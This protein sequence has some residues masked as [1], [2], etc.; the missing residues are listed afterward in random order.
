MSPNDLETFAKVTTFF[1]QAIPEIEARQKQNA[2][3]AELAKSIA[4]KEADK[5]GEL[6]NTIVQLWGEEGSVL[7]FPALRKYFFFCVLEQEEKPENAVIQANQRGEHLLFLLDISSSMNH[8]EQGNYQAPGSRDHQASS[9][10]KAR[11]LIAPLIMSALKRNCPVTVVPWNSR[12]KPANI[13]EFN[14]KDFL[15]GETGELLDDAMLQPEL[16]KRTSESVFTASSATNIE[17]ALK[18]LQTRCL[19][20]ART[21]S[22]ISMWFLTDGEET[23]YLGPNG[24]SLTIPVNPAD[25]QYNYFHAVVDGSTEYQKVMIKLMESLMKRLSEYKTSL[26]CHWCHF[27]EADPLF[28]R[29]LRQVTQGHFHAVA[30][31]SK[32]R[33]EMLA[34][35]HAPVSKLAM[36]LPSGHEFPVAAAEAFGTLFGRGELS[37]EH[38]SSIVEKKSLKLKNQANQTLALP[39]ND[40]STM[41]PT[42]LT[43]VET[44]LGL[45]PTLSKLMSELNSNIN[46]DAINRVSKELT[47]LKAARHDAIAQI[48]KTVKQGSLIQSFLEKVIQAVEGQIAALSRML[49]QYAAPEAQNYDDKQA[50]NSEFFTQREQ[51]AISAGLESMKVRIGAGFI[52]QACLDKRI[53]QI[54]VSKGPWARKMLRRKCIIVETER[55]EVTILSLLIVDDQYRTEC[56]HKLIKEMTANKPAVE[57]LA[58]SAFTFTETMHHDETDQIIST[59]LV[60]SPGLIEKRIVPTRQLYENIC[61][62]YTVSVSSDDLFEAKK[63]LLDPLSYANFLELIQENS[64]LPAY[65]YTVATDQSPGLLFSAKEMLAVLSGGSDITSFAYFRLFWRLADKDKNNAVKV[66]GTFHAANAALPM[67]PDP[68]SNLVLAN[69]MPGLMSEFITGTPMAPLSEIGIIY[70][71]Y[72]LLHLRAH[73]MVDIDFQRVGEFLCTISCWIDNPKTAPKQS[74][75]QETIDRIV[76]DQ[77]ITTQDSPGKVLPVKAIA[78]LLIDGN[79]DIEV[80]FS[81]LH[82]EIFNRLT[83]LLTGKISGMQAGKHS[84]RLIDNQLYLRDYVNDVLGAIGEELAI[85]PKYTEDT[86]DPEIP[87]RIINAANAIKMVLESEDQKVHDDFFSPKVVTI[88]AQKMHYL[89]HTVTE[90]CFGGNTH[91]KSLQKL[92]FYF[93]IIGCFPLASLKKTYALYQEANAFLKHCKFHSEHHSK[94]DFKDVICSWVNRVD[95]R[96]CY[97]S[98]SLHPES[99]FVLNNHTLGQ[100][101]A[102]SHQRAIIVLWPLFKSIFLRFSQWKSREY[103][104]HGLLE[105][106][107]AVVKALKKPE[108]QSFLAGQQLTDYNQALAH[109]NK[110]YSP[111]V[112][113]APEIK[114]LQNNTKV[115]MKARELS[116]KSRISVVF[117]GA[118]DAGKSTTAGQ[119]ISQSGFIDPHL[120]KQ[121]EK[122]ARDLGKESF[123]FAW[124]MDR[125]KNERERGI[126][127]E[128]SFWSIATP[129]HEV[130][131]LDAP[132]HR[133][134]FKNMAVGASLADCAILVASAAPQEFEPSIETEGML[135]QEAFCAFAVGIR[136]FIVCVNKMDAVNYSEARFNEVSF[137][138]QRMLKK[139]GVQPHQIAVV[140]ISAWKGLNLMKPAEEFKWFQGWSWIH[141]NKTEHKGITLQ[142]AMDSIEAPER[143]P[144]TPLRIP[145]LKNHKI[146]GIG[147][148]G[149]GRVA[150][151]VIKK[152][153]KLVILP[154]A[155]EAE[156]NTIELHHIPREEGGPGDV[157]G[158]NVKKIHQ[159]QL[160]RGMVAVDPKVPLIPVKKFVIRVAITNFKNPIKVGWQCFCFCHTASF[161]IKFTKLVSKMDKKTGKVLEANPESCTGGDAM[162]IEVETEHKVCVEPFATCPPLGRICCTQNGK[163]VALGVVMSIVQEAPG[164]KTLPKTGQ[165]PPGKGPAGRGQPA[166][167]VP[168]RGRR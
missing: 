5:R 153:Q 93:S 129:N 74:D 140:P 63:R 27:G 35:A 108:L 168:A 105:I 161:S 113:K 116:D 24:E 3:D 139:L 131:I 68:L 17:A 50:A 89:L 88:L 1:Y 157:I 148:V 47:K 160:T 127:I 162:M 83:K 155:I 121:F 28:L 48:G 109:K 137:E 99:S 13:V 4:K 119:M 164:P 10:K 31:I 154:D 142:D 138:M 91:W 117:L 112:P 114:Q 150:S 126:S 19:E 143:N 85:H 79:H 36:V 90:K 46:L 156:C 73:T 152:G 8:D 111:W 2:A 64:T 86:A 128:V 40:T 37:L 51:F 11:A 132:G 118:V 147:L 70:T 30:D 71:G 100:Q 60:Q 165:A 78:Y 21:C 62:D 29:A 53:Q 39:Y 58:P 69:I 110:L 125:L 92:L 12:I 14:P 72:M 82:N 84:Q 103:S 67:A 95:D 163:I 18:Y 158:F 7:L 26:D 87:I 54:I 80:K 57:G 141:R 106:D 55:D 107:Y 45:E 61:A 98:L 16:V 23:R 133:D 42:L 81:A 44:V 151:G 49:E 56:Q 101:E 123:K 94:F 122:D 75:V 38:Y 97:F 22:G 166:K 59:V 159:E 76:K 9:I 130:D 33:Q 135:Q 77:T 65:L 25:V 6:N 15:D 102:L 136:Q 66:P 104:A 34:A 146:A 115:V 43:A 32:L 134:F 167:A 96:L 20:L 124:V 120:M 149:I 52:P 41:H 145:I 144:N